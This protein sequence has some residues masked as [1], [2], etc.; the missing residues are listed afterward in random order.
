[1]DYSKDNVRQFIAA[2]T[3]LPHG[4]SGS[5]VKWPIDQKN[6]GAQ[7]GKSSDD[8]L[9]LMSIQTLHGIFQCALQDRKISDG[10]KICADQTGPFRQFFL[11]LL[12]LLSCGEVD[13]W[14]GEQIAEERKSIRANGLAIVRSLLEAQTDSKGAL[15]DDCCFDY[16]GLSIILC[17]EGEALLLMDYNNPKNRLYLPG[18]TI[19]QL[20]TRVFFAW[21]KETGEPVGK[22]D[23]QLDF[24]AIDFTNRNLNCADLIAVLNNHG[25]PTHAVITEPINASTVDLNALRVNRHMALHLLKLHDNPRLVLIEYLKFERLHGRVPIDLSGMDLTR[26]NLSGVNLK[27]IRLNGAWYNEKLGLAELDEDTRI[28]V[29]L[30][31][32]HADRAATQIQATFRG[33]R[34]F[35]KKETPKALLTVLTDTN[36]TLM[37]YRFPDPH[38]ALG[39]RLAAMPPATI[40][41]TPGAFSR[42]THLDQST[43]GFVVLTVNDEFNDKVS[44]LVTQ[45]ANDREII[46]LIQ[47]Q[48]LDR[49][50]LKY[51]INQRQSMSKFMGARD[52]LAQLQ[53]GQYVYSRQHY[54]PMAQD[55]Q[56]L[57]DA[58]IVH[59][60]IKPANWIL[61]DGV[62]YLLDPD[63]LTKIDRIASRAGTKTYLHPTLA[64]NFKLNAIKI[65]QHCFFLSMM[66]AYHTVTPASDGRFN[67]ILINDFVNSLPCPGLRNELA[68]FIDEPASH[69]LTHPLY[70]YL[71]EPE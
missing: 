20:K 22:Y 8:P 66:V 61:K 32:L 46:Q 30:W 1:M 45:G 12:N 69:N 6:M 65:D 29:R 36:G 5:S 49:L 47:K 71:L 9:M 4:N 17:Q 35:H 31:K 15:S 25:D 64:V 58:G 13:T 3:R 10:A 59:R 56:K 19:Q 51:R 67:T 42:I 23:G 27:G 50:V 70:S 18:T 38:K 26:I 44:D 63:F 16:A 37:R 57:H 39:Y 60:D 43:A 62:M 21:L 52:L 41:P 40:H 2:T 68:K 54:I 34:V 11:W 33:H 48:K 7:H 55:L 24:S 53:H 28:T 14:I